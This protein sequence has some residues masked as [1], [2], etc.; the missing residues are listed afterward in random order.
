DVLFVARTP[1][2]VASVRAA[3]ERSLE[4]AVQ[5]GKLDDADRTAALARISGTT[6]LDDLSGVHPV[7]EAVVEDLTV[8]QALF[9][10]LDEICA[11]GTVLATTTSS[12]PVIEC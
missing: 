3:I 12:L 7:V 1:E 4:K 10:N 9:S 5:R 6:R 8:K 11:P 2:K